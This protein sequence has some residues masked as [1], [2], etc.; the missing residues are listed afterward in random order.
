MI[1]WVDP[2]DGVVDA[3]QPPGVTALHVEGP[4]GTNPACWQPCATGRGGPNVIT[5]VV[6]DAPGRYRLLLGQPIT[7]STAVIRYQTQGGSIGACFRG[8]PGNVDGDAHTGPIDILKL[9]DCLNGVAPESSCPWGLYSCDADHSLVCDAE[10]LLLVITL[11][12]GEGPLL[13]GW[14][15]APLPLC[16]V[17]PE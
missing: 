1:T 7:S 8:L 10:D 3:R 5:S 17:C 14:N 16:P 12:R 9:V 2:P 11:L 4:C 13:P 15:G 6:E